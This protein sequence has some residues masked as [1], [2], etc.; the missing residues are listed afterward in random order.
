MV[1]SIGSSRSTGRATR[2]RPDKAALRVGTLCHPG[3]PDHGLARD[4]DPG[5]RRTKGG[6]RRLDREGCPREG[7]RN[8]PKG[9]EYLLGFA[10]ALFFAGP[11]LF[12]KVSSSSREDTAIPS[13]GGALASPSPTQ[14]GPGP[15]ERPVTGSFRGHGANVGRKWKMRS[16]RLRERAGKGFRLP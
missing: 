13:H 11:R 15:I 16:K 1:R 6:G 10:G 7:V 2:N 3:R 12:A 4:P 9:G 8:E 14:Q 5:S